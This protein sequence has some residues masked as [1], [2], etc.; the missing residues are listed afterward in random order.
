MLRELEFLIDTCPPGTM[1]LI[2]QVI[3]ATRDG[4][5]AFRRLVERATAKGIYI[6]IMQL[7]PDGF[8]QRSGGDQVLFF[9]NRDGVE[10]NQSAIRITHE[11]AG[12]VGDA[13]AM[14]KA[15]AEAATG[16][17]LGTSMRHRRSKCI[18]DADAADMDLSVADAL[19]VA[20]WERDWRDWQTLVACWRWLF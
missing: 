13:L 7:G 9:V 20:S 10:E 18:R 11:G 14:S 17:S 15:L 6:I 8:Y 2:G 3:R 19:Q 12:V 4:K 1:I 5:A 16:S